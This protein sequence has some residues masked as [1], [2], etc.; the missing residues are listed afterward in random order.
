[1][2]YTMV[3]CS[4]GCGKKFPLGKSGPTGWKQ[5]GNSVIRL[6]DNVKFSKGAT[7]QR[8]AESGKQYCDLVITSVDFYDHHGK[9]SMYIRASTVPSGDKSNG[10]INICDT[11]IDY[12]SADNPNTLRFI[13]KI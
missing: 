13:E 8:F 6:S 12:M 7:I 5:E 4:C 2:K 1:M 10:S 3:M 11:E 9:K